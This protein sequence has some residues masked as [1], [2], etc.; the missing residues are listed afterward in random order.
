MEH[1]PA[2]PGTL[3]LWK[4]RVE[5]VVEVIFLIEIGIMLVILPWTNVWTQNSLLTGY[6]GVQSVINHG[7]VRGAI[8]GLGLINIYIGIH[9]A[10]VYREAP[11]S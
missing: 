2:A 1:T 10:V 4:R 3:A 6:P 11:R 5:L 7:F 8:S 9:D